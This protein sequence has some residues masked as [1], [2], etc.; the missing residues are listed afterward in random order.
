[1]LSLAEDN[2]QPPIPQTVADH[3][4]WEFYNIQQ[5]GQFLILKNFS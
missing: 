5:P 4:C 3:W 2:H 1:M